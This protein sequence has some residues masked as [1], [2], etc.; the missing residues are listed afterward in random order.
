MRD[1][2]RCFKISL[3]IFRCRAIGANKA[4]AHGSNVEGDEDM[5]EAFR[6]FD[7]NGD[8]YIIVDELGA[9]LAASVAEPGLLIKG[10]RIIR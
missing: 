1:I 4:A 8:R 3:G 5:R 10:G 6:V 7:A 2:F 9:V